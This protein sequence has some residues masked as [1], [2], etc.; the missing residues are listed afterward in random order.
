MGSRPT[1]LL[2]SSLL[3]VATPAF[4]QTGIDAQENVF[5]ATNIHAVVGH[6][7]LTAGVSREGDLTVLSW[8]SPSYND[9]L[10]YLSSNALDARSQP[11]FGALEGAGMFLGL[12]C[13]QAGGSSEVTWLREDPWTIE[14][15]YGSADGPHPHTRFRNDTLGLSVTLVDAIDPKSATLVRHVTIVRDTDSPVQDAWL[16]SY[17]NLSPLPPGSRV[18]ELHVAD[19]FKDGEND[20]AAAWHA[21][22][23]AVVHFHPSGRRV[24][25]D[26]ISLTTS[27]EVEWGPVGDALAATTIDEAALADLVADLPNAYGDGSWLALSTVPAPDQHQVGFDGTPQ[28]PHLDALIANFE[29]LPE[30]FPAFTPPID[31]ELASQLACKKLPEEIIAEQG[32]EYAAADPYTDAQDGDLEGAGL[33]AGEVAEALRTPLSF[34]AAGSATVSVVLGAG[35]TFSAA[36]QA[37]GA[38]RDADAL[39][40][41]SNQAVSEWLGGLR[42]P[43]ADGTRVRDVAR[44][45]LI[46]LRVGTDAGTGAVVA[47]IARQPPYALDWPRDGAFF[48]VML[49]A[50]GQTDLVAKRL[51][52]YESWQRATTARPTPFIDPPAPVDP[53]TGSAVYPA[54]AWEMNYYADGT[55]G[56]TFRF[57]IDTT[58]FAVWSLV[59]HVGWAEDPE[60][61]LEKHWDAIERGAEL[62]AGWRDAET[63]LHA[64]AQEDDSAAH[65]QTLHG[66][67]TVFGALDIAARAA[68]RLGR[69]SLA[70]RWENRARELRSAIQDHFYEPDEQVFFMTDSGRLPIQASGLVPTGPTA[71]L[72]WPCTLF[73]FEDDRIQRQLHRDYGI[74]EPVLKLETKGGLYYMKNTISIAVAGGEDFGSIIASLPETLANEATPGTDHFGEV[75]V[76]VD[77]NGERVPEQRVSTPH[78]WEG[79]LFYL[80]ALAAEDPAALIAYDA[81]L[82]PSRVLT[83]ADAGEV[84]AG[85]GC[86]CATEDGASEARWLAWA[87][88]VL[89]VA[90]AAAR[91]SR[92]S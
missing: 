89:A 7:G 81:Q 22:E 14:Q 35:E 21:E 18:S 76:V 73:P 4:A 36:L 56:G 1:L 39:I 37:L 52:L 26:L 20:F 55:P 57:E 3:L 68:R 23:H 86:D 33:A 66:A 69:D 59:A 34:D 72:V 15:D 17:A 78:L 9:Q 58:A 84:A 79:T 60:G 61:H 31:P 24:Y 29:E 85:G 27:G 70:R 71:W 43:G 11:R 46:N 30:V 25:R 50:S 92:S 80:T 90:A 48:N 65:T 10:A 67:I 75:M 38:G 13:D 51:E 28:C 2:V 62:L 8:P 74:I 41:R 88:V 16:L 44:R 40:E 64:P 82:P 87:G 53:R 45:S 32:W 5:G 77:R 12:R 54:D 91:R 47:S 83:G 19:W 6:G 49:D 42:V 63:G